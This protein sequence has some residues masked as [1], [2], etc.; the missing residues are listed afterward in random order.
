MDFIAANVDKNDLEVVTVNCHRP[1]ILVQFWTNSDNLDEA[2]KYGIVAKAVIEV[3]PDEADKATTS[4]PMPLFRV[5]YDIKVVDDE[6]G[7]TGEIVTDLR[8]D[9]VTTL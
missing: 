2:P 4:W 7:E 5:N 3:V 9:W 8:G 1:G 6:G